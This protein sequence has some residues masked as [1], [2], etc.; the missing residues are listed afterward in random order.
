MNHNT[1]LHGDQKRHRESSTH[2]EASSQDTDITPPSST[3]S[4]AS[5][6]GEGEMQGAKEEEER[7]EG[8]GEGD[9]SRSRGGEVKGQEVVPVENGLEQT[10]LPGTRKLWT[11]NGIRDKTETGGREEGGGRRERVDESSPDAVRRR[12]PS[13]EEDETQVYTPCPCRALLPAD[14]QCIMEAHVHVCTVSCPLSAVPLSL[15]LSLSLPF[16]LSPSRPLS[17]SLPFSLSPSPSLPLPL[18]LSLSAV[19]WVTI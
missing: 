12:G 1:V 8:G 18:S 17:L 19:S 13:R 16:S 3:H 14:L 5:Q 9:G 7:E 4:S 6:L 2:S 15:S 10:V 11:R